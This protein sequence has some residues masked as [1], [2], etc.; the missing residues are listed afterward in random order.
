MPQ[1]PSWRQAEELAAQVDKANEMAELEHRKLQAELQHRAE[2]MQA[3]TTQ[4]SPYL[5][6]AGN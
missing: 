3:F 4:V 1:R 6:E 2:V 5:G